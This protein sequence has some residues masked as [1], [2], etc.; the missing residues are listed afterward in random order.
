VEALTL[1][2]PVTYYLLFF[3]HLESRKAEI[4]GITTHPTE[5]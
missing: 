5:Q 4:A 3:I 2:R 1:R